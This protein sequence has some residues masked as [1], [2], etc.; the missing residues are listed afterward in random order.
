MKRF[1]IFAGSVLLSL[2]VAACGAAAMSGG[3][4]PAAKKA[5]V[6][7]KSV[8]GLG[9]VLTNATGLALYTNSRDTGS[10]MPQCNGA[11]AVV[12]KPLTVKGSVGS[13]TLGTLGVVKRSNGTK[14]VT[15]NGKPVYTFKFDQP[16]K[17]TG[18]G[19]TDSFSSQTFTWHVVN[20]G[21]GGSS[22]GGTTT[23]GYGGGSGGTT[24]GY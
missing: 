16:G 6:T 21:G 22:G 8:K 20:V 7:S 17:V 18:N 10:S 3:G 9:S 19:A 12:W 13:S 14:Q 5:I 1:F 11:C 24:P 23:P 4:G 2:T 15:F